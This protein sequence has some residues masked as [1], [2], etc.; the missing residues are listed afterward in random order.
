MIRLFA[1]TAASLIALTAAASAAPEL[2]R[3]RGTIES[4]TDTTL[5]IKTRDGA[6]QQV[7]VQPET[8]FLNVVKSSLD[9]VGE[10]KFIGTATKG[11][12]KFVALEV[13]IFP[14]S[15]KGTGEGHYAWDEITDTTAGGGAMATTKSSMTNG[16]VKAKPAGGATTKSSM[17]N[18][19]VKTSGGSGGSKTIEVAYGEGQSKTITVPPSAPIVAFEPGDKT[20]A[21]KGAPVFVVTIHDGDTVKTRTV[22]VGKDGVVPPM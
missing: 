15:M 13:V 14:E 10:G 9:Q 19:T 4:A 1:L 22:A 11:D 3:I 20:I 8:K 21:I 7:T 2:V 5:T 16:T 17:T 6:T 12:D 18:G